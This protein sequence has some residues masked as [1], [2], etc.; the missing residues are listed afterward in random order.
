MHISQSVVCALHETVARH[1]SNSTEKGKKSRLALFFIPFLSMNFF[2]HGNLNNGF[3][4]QPPTYLL[5]ET[6]TILIS[7]FFR[8]NSYTTLYPR[9]GKARV[10][11]AAVRAYQICVRNANDRLPLLFVKN[12]SFQGETMAPLPRTLLPQMSG[13]LLN[14]CRQRSIGTCVV[15]DENLWLTF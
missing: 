2:D 4:Q 6:V 9:Y 7:Q 1:V 15:Q 13:E 10:R 8:L 12:S 11:L 5:M 3:G 14:F